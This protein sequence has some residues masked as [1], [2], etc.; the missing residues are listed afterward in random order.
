MLDLASGTNLA[1][2]EES[3]NLGLQHRQPLSTIF[4]HYGSYDSVNLM[5]G[6]LLFHPEKRLQIEHVL[7]HPFINRYK[8]N[9][10][11]NK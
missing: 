9:R 4:Q 1:M 7:E 6:L 5:E 11:I 10:R 8:N 2:L 3:L